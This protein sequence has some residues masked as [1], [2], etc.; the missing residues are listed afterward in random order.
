[1]TA[2]EHDLRR[3]LNAAQD[4]LANIAAVADRDDVKRRHR[5]LAITETVRAWR[6]SQRAVE[7]RYDE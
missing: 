4:A 3:Q 6:E 1:M 5:L 7:R 2:L